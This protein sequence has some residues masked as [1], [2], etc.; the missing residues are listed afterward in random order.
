[1]VTSLSQD[2]SWL[3]TLTTRQSFYWGIIA[4]CCEKIPITEKHFDWVYL[5][6]S[7]IR[8]LGLIYNSYCK[9]K[10]LRPDKCL[11]STDGFPQLSAHSKH[12]IKYDLNILHRLTIAVCV[13]DR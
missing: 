11:L 12:I 5:Y 3:Q 13:F 7:A 2:L 6:E 8:N 1:M 10:E 4:T 9:E